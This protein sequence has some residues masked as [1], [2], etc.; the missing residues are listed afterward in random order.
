MIS[1]LS[2][3]E[4]FNFFFIFVILFLM[5]ISFFLFKKNKELKNEIDLLK[6]ENKKLLEKRIAKSDKEDL[7]SIKSIS[8]EKKS[9]T[10]K[11]EDKE[12]EAKLK[13]NKGDVI[14]KQKNDKYRVK[15]NSV[16]SL[17]SY[18]ELSNEEKVKGYTNKNYQKSS[19]QN[20]NKVTSPITIKNDDAFDIDKLSL[21]LNEF[22]KKSKKIV[23]QIKESSSNKEYLRDISDKLSKEIEA[24]TI[25]LTSYE[26]AQEENAVISYQELLSIKDK[27][28]IEDD[29]DNNINFIDELKKFRDNL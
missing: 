19:F 25:E 9:N 15:N 21:D 20:K 5:L 17:N 22:I 13:I 7:I 16:Q 1:I 24:Q 3:K 26:K 2:I 12:L 8:N 27:I 14:S 18:K 29:E 4:S 10:L 23:P 28:M 11:K 6:E